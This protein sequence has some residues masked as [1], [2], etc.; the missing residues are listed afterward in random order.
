MG[1]MR[2]AAA[3]FQ[4]QEMGGPKRKI[5][6]GIN[7]AI[8][9]ENSVA[10][11]GRDRSPTSGELQIWKTIL[12]DIAQQHNAWAKTNKVQTRKR[13]GETSLRIVTFSV[14]RDNVPALKKTFTE[15][16]FQVGGVASVTGLSVVGEVISPLNK[17][18]PLQIK[19]L[20]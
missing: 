15:A 3:A 13:E 20:C 4:R 6:N 1:Q 8:A 9:F 19:A 17:D 16:N 11:G 7:I 18:V 10:A 12:V 5:L 14:P 2:A